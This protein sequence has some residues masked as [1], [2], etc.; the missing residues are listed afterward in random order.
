MAYLVVLVAVALYLSGGNH[1]EAKR[2]LV[3]KELIPLLL[4]LP[5][6]WLASVFQR[7]ASFL[8][9]LRG[10]YKDAVASIQSAIQYTHKAEPSQTD[11]GEVNK[12]ISTSID[13]FRGSF[14][15]L[16]E[17]GAS[18]GLFPFEALKTVREWIDYLG[19]GQDATADKRKATR[20]AI[21]ALWQNQIR[22]PLLNELDREIP[23]T[24]DSPFWQSGDSRPVWNR[25]PKRE[26]PREA[27]N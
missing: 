15:N 9:T 27:A 5:T 26:Q 14:R 19:F 1:P 6:A 13:L 23:T 24:F 7:R 3:F 21:V 12:Q 8:T 2:F 10:L 20:D 22:K 25:P 11:F 16:E 4:A 17:S 18:S